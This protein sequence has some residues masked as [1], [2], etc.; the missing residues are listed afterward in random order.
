MGVVEKIMKFRGLTTPMT[1]EEL[2]TDIF[3]P[4]RDSYNVIEEHQPEVNRK[5]EEFL[6]KNAREEYFK[7]EQMKTI[8]YDPDIYIALT[9]RNC[10]K[11]YSYM[12]LCSELIDRGEEFVIVRNSLTELKTAVVQQFRDY[13]WMFRNDIVVKNNCVYERIHYEEEKGKKVVERYE[14]K[15]VGYLAYLSGVT[16]AFQGSSYPKAKTII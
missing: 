8:G 4:W 15:L 1:K 13:S 14:D 10:G 16:Q 3:K 2:E 6:L 5:Y 11:T 7:I 9:K 12:R